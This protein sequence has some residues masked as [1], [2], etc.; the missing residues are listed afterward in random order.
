MS[1]WISITVLL[2]SVLTFLGLVALAIFTKRIPR[3]RLDL[4]HLADEQRHLAHAIQPLVAS[5]PPIDCV[6]TRISFSESFNS[7]LFSRI[8]Q[9]CALNQV[10]GLLAARASDGITL[11]INA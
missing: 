5:G 4:G 11:T 1:D 6:I 2:I 3:Q 8:S 9:Q 10:N 7:A